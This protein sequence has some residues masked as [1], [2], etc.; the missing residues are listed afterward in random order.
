[1]AVLRVLLAAAVVG[2]A[3]APARG[4]ALPPVKH[5]F[6]IVLENKDFDQSFG[7]DSPATYISK[8]LPRR[9]QVLEQYFGTSHVSLGN[10]I[11][12]I[13]GQAPNPDTQS[14]CNSGFR[15]IFPGAPTADGQ[16]LGV[17]CVYPAAI[18]TVVDQLEAEGLGWR[19]Y[20]QDMGNSPTEPKTCRHPGIGES[21]QTQS[22][23]VGDQYATRH[24][25]FVYFHSIIDDQTRCDAHVVGLEQLPPDLRRAGSTPSYVFITPNLCDDGH[26]APCVDGRPGGLVSA[27]A[28]V[29]NWAPQILRSPAYAQ[30]GLLIVTWDEGNLGPDTSEACCGEPSGPSTPQPGILGPG[31][32]RTGTVVVSP[33]TQPG[34]RNKTPYNHYAMLRSVED[35]FGLAHLG[36]AGREGLRAFG[37]DVFNAVPV[38]A[39]CAVM[40]PLP[41]PRSHVYPR[42]SFLA[43]AELRG[44]TLTLTARRAGRL[45]VRLAGRRIAAPPRLTHCLT[46]RVGLPAAHGAV[47]VALGNARGAERRRLR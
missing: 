17:G 16:V 20:M 9:G 45:T 47:R 7:K 29:K 31:G 5:V 23:R 21:D 34:T 13:S 42:G 6:V 11:S 39:P 8:T 32:G 2:L 36:Y 12:M 40:S 22:A 27:D 25:P 35:L 19:G 14:D 28:F 10:Y 30:G 24:D 41:R 43:G 4:A 1:V 3:G 44:R 33:F 26:D 37:A 18:K 38:G 46:A 15:D